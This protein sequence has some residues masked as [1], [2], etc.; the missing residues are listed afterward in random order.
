MLL[1]LGCS[2]I[3]EENNVSVT[4]LHELIESSE[5]TVLDVRT[6]KEIA[7]GKIVATAL[8]ADFFEDNFIEEATSKISKDETI[9]VYCKGGNRSAKA[10]IKLR[11]LGYLKAYNVEG[12]IKAWKAE[13]YEI[14]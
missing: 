14:E 13:N 10:V 6:P 12:G 4:K 8:E 11:E 3:P 5:I 9:Y 1:F 2:N 7:Q